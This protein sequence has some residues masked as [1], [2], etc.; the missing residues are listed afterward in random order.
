MT[1]H[2]APL[3]ELVDFY[4][5]G[6]PSKSNPD[7][8]DGDV[9]WFSAKDMK[10]PRLVDTTTHVSELVFRSTPLRKLPVGTVVL[11]VRGMIL[12]H[13]VPIATLG[14][15]AAI[16]QDLKALL[17]RD[18]VDPSFLASML[19]AQHSTILTQVSTA[20]HGTKRLESRILENIQIPVPPIEEQRRI[21]AILDHADSLLERQR[22]SL[23]RI[24]SVATTA[25]DEKFKNCRTV[26]PLGEV[27]DFYGGSSLPAGLPFEGQDD[28]FL[29]LKVSDMNIPGNE[30]EV[31]APAAWS[32][33]PGPRASTCPSGSVVIPK[34]G[35]AIAT[36]KK[37]VVRRPAIL[38]PNL[39]A[40][41]PRAGRLTT[42]YLL[43]WLQAF[44]LSQITSGS[45]VPQ[46]NKRDLAPLEIPVP[47]MEQQLE[48]E[49]V[50]ERVGSLRAASE[51]RTQ[52]L[53]MLFASLQARAFV[54]EL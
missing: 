49:H 7:F 4:S 5:G 11:V 47:T 33:R 14:V 31:R 17:P 37:R 35:A 53:A 22:Q 40:I 3:G 28:G 24:A 16:N 38:D 10:S 29:M 23:R 18:D 9:P 8:W 36:N 45:S 30:I 39:M 21:A 41:A 42:A 19:R 15:D 34:R 20:A 48:F 6:T 25:F 50:V 52:R 54:G 32:S 26:L 2:M 27:A 43:S 1:W 12:A 44:D 51:G 13:T 46:L